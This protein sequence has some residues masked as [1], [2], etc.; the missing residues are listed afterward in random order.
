MVDAAAP[1]VAAGTNADKPGVPVRGPRAG[2]PSQ[3]RPPVVQPF[4]LDLIIAV[5]E[6]G[7]VGEH[8]W[9]ALQIDRDFDDIACGAGD[10]RNN[11]CLATSYL[12]EKA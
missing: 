10:R 1:A 9:V 3:R 12:I 6:P 5:A 4:L 2:T 8:H 7:G 11:G